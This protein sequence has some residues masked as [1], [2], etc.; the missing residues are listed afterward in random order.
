VERSTIYDF[1]GGRDAFLA[2]A[3]ALHERCLADP[4]L[5]HPFSHA[6]D[7]EHLVHLADYLGEVFGGPA[8][9]SANGGH[10][11]MLAIH[12]STG[13]DPEMATRFVECFDLAVGDA[14]LPEDPAFR[15]VLH[16]YLTWAAREVDGYGPIGSVVPEGLAFPRWSWGGPET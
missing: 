8:T 3:A 15:R 4:V 11:H 7:P 14:G 5:N 16:D 10:S 13:A 12:A 1:A 6:T 9:Y 2:L